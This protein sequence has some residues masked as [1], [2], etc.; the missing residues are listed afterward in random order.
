MPRGR[1]SLCIHE[2]RHILRTLY[3]V[4][5][6]TL[7][8][9]SL[10]IGVKCSFAKIPDLSPPLDAKGL[11]VINVVVRL[12]RIIIRVLRCQCLQCCFAF[13]KI[14]ADPFFYDPRR[15]FIID[16]LRAFTINI[17][18]PIIAGHMFQ[19]SSHLGTIA[20]LTGK[21]LVISISLVSIQRI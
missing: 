8:S 16:T 1:R 7:R 5:L 15:L 18:P 10:N 9:E 3:L 13:L 6:P 21:Q 20:N 17:C 11:T 4:R 2:Q 12:R 14:L 19:A